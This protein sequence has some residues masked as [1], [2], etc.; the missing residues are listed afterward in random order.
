M[1]HSGEPFTKQG[2]SAEWLALRE[3]PIELRAS[4][5]TAF[6]AVRIRAAAGEALLGRSLVGITDACVDA[7]ALWSGA[8][9][10][11]RDLRHAGSFE[12]Q[13]DV[14]DSFLLGRL[15]PLAG[16]SALLQA[17]LRLEKSGGVAATAAIA[18][19]SVRQ[20]ENRFKAA[21]GAAPSRF[22]RLARFR[23]TMKALLLAPA[24]QPMTE[25]LDPTYVDQAQFI[26]DCRAFAGMAPGAWRLRARDMQHFYMT[27][28]PD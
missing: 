26:H 14:I 21:T 10:L 6:I 27:G 5:S 1:F 8:Q 28:L 4:P 9:E 19:W 11:C 15:R 13:A 22:R 17:A 7:T 20:F 3:R 16:Q 18:G 25:L 2:S 12:A 24:E 23:R